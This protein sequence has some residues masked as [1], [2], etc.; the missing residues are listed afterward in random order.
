MMFMLKKPAWLFAIFLGAATVALMAWP[1]LDPARAEL[2]PVK[3]YTS[4]DGL[5]QNHITRIVVDSRGFIWVCTKEGFSRYD[6]YQF[7]SFGVEEGLPHRTV[8]DLLETPTGD[9]WLATDGGLIRFNPAGASHPPGKSPTNGRA[10]MFTRYPLPIGKPDTAINALAL[11]TDGSIWCGSSAG[12]FQL[13]KKNGEYSL[14]PT[15]LSSNGPEDYFVCSLLVDR[16]GIVWV[17]GQKGR[18]HRLHPDG[19][20]ES[21]GS[22]EGMPDL[23][24]SRLYQDQEGRV[25]AGTGRGLHELHRQPVAGSQSIVKRIISIKDGMPGDWVRDVWQ[26]PHK[27]YWVATDRGLFKF[28]LSKDDRPES[29]AKYVKENGLSDYYLQCITGD[30]SGNIWI[31]T[32]NAGIMRWAFN[33]FTTYGYEDGIASAVSLFQSRDGGVRLAGFVPITYLPDEMAWGRGQ[34]DLPL[35]HWRLGRLEKEKF[36]WVRPNVGRKV[37]FT[38]GWNQISFQDSRGDWWIATQQGLYRYSGVRALEDLASATPSAVYTARDGLQNNHVTRLFEDSRG[39]IWIGG[40]SDQ[41]KSLDRWDRATNRIQNISPVNGLAPLENKEVNALAEDRAGNIWL[42]LNSR[43]YPAGLARYKDGKFTFFTELNTIPLGNIASLLIDST[44]RLW[45]ASTTQGAIRLDDPNSANPA[46]QFFN[47]SGGLVS[48]RVTSLAEDNFGNIYFGTARGVDQLD[49][50]SG[51]IRHFS[52]ADG[53][54]LGSIDDILRDAKGDLWFATTQGLSRYTPHPSPPLPPPPIYIDSI[55]IN[56]RPFPISALGE[57]AVTLPLLEPTENQIEIAYVGLSFT[58]G[59][60]LSYQYQLKGIDR[61][62]ESQ[63]GKRTVTYANLAPGT[64]QFLVR[65]INVDKAASDPPASVSFTIEAPYWRRWWFILLCLGIGAGAIWAAIRIRVRRLLEVEKMRSRIATDLHDD[66]GSTLSQ[67]AILSEVARRQAHDQT[68]S[69]DVSPMEKVAA[70]SREAIDSMND[71]VWSITP[72]RDH[73]RDL[74]QRMRRFASDTLS[75]IDIA[76]HF[77]APEEDLAL[78][79]DLR[80]EV[81]MIFKECVNNIAR[82][83]QATE[84]GIELTVNAHQ[85]TLRIWDNGRGFVEASLPADRSGGNGLPSLRRRAA[86]IGGAIDVVSAPGQ[87][88]SVTLKA[89]LRKRKSL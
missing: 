59:D 9:Y 25:W 56:G 89:P 32:A 21:F 35:L 52:D 73:L 28:V 14:N 33:G 30:K 31:G 27:T 38:L 70:T 80:R 62:W 63:G 72:Q 2:L 58:P 76:L 79:V 47:T 43:S 16:E 41:L 37:Y 82:H 17:G 19:K 84:A 48:N 64:Y 69:G 3:S 5:A 44:G 55:R 85:L 1:I 66:V 49:Q 67:I 39:D 40:S 6:G 83:S 26:A 13:V 60:S 65:A 53:L 61:D 88:T 57:P 68:D 54:A 71:I 51:K 8:N 7:H 20:V 22:S 10:A 36:I 29:V 45:V 34:K 24:V 42:G 50:R 74:V 86:N 81:F 87:G 78:G 11:G 23:E 12:L 77:H 18:V 75:A 4:S 46:F 15:P